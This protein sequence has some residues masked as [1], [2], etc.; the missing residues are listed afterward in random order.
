MR[1]I[2]IRSV[3]QRKTKDNRDY[4]LVEDVDGKKYYTFDKKLFPILASG[5]RV[6]AEVSEGQRGFLRITRAERVEERDRNEIIAREV[7]LKAAADLVA[8]Q[9]GAGKD[10]GPKAVI[11]YAKYF[12]DWLLQK[13]E[14]EGEL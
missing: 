7:A 14:G 13:D 6:R 5:G 8:F 3:S 2:E 10:V 9:I 12:T 1:E 11:E 4:F